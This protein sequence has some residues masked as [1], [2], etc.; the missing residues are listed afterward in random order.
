MAKPMPQWPAT[1]TDFID[2]LRPGIQKRSA[3]ILSVVSSNWFRK[4]LLQ[5]SGHLFVNRYVANTLLRQMHAGLKAHQ[6][7]Q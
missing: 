6:L 5:L 4:R 3:A 7:C 1:K 2:E